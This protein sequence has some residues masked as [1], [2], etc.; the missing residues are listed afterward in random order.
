MK[1]RKIIL[2]VL[3]LIVLG[4]VVA[5]GKT[6]PKEEA[7]KIETEATEK[8][9]SEE[10]EVKAEESPESQR[11]EVSYGLM[12]GPTAVGSI[13]LL[14]KSKAGQSHFI[15]KETI[16]GTPDEIVANLIKGDLDL[17]VIPA[18]LASV[19]YNKTGGKIKLL[20]SNNLGVLSIIEVGD[21]VH[22]LGDLKGKTI[23]APG[24]N[25][26]PD[27]IFNYLMAKNNFI[28]GTDYQ[29]EFKTEATEVLNDLEAGLGTLALLP[30]PMATVILTKNER[31]RLAVDLNQEWAKINEGQQFT[32]VLVARSE[33]LDNFDTEGFLKEYKASIEEA[34]T[35]V[36]ATANLLEKYNVFKAPIAKK[37]IPN[38]NLA[39]M[40]KEDLQESMEAYLDILFAVNPNFIGG[41][42]PSEDFY[43][44]GK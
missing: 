19:L 13:N 40:D 38:M 2:L 27:I 30:E 26:T 28:E 31:A 4:T 14:E 35:N 15:L 16:T 10:T 1:N 34:V 17:A 21:E 22:S 36:D 5:C 33:F 29:I 41:E 43:Y 23:L 24:K 3:G 12:T 11:V 7:Q 44:L 39:Y 42:K 20:A 25:A 32:G 18:N 6:G 9:V 8:Q 37:A